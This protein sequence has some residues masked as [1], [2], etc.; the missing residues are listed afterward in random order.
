MLLVVSA[1]S[2]VKMK[3]WYMLWYRRRRA[4]VMRPVSRSMRMYGREKS[5]VVKATNAV[6]ATRKTLSGSTKNWS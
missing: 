1:S 5:E 4:A 6:S 3:S 2:M